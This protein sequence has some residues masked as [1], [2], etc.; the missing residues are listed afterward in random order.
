LPLAYCIAGR[1]CE[2]VL[3]ERKTGIRRGVV[4]VERGRPLE[5]LDRAPPTVG[6]PASMPH[7]TRSRDRN[8]HIHT[9]GDTDEEG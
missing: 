2:D 1:I 7:E 8:K 5:G 4:R 9:P 3:R 6:V